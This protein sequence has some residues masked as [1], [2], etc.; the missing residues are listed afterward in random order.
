ME[1]LSLEILD[2][3]SILDCPLFKLH[4]SS[5]GLEGA[6]DASRYQAF[7]QTHVA[8]FAF[9]KG[10]E[11]SNNQ[12]WKEILY[13]V[14]FKASYAMDTPGPLEGRQRSTSSG[15]KKDIQNMFHASIDSDLSLT[16]NK[17]VLQNLIS[18]QAQLS[19][20]TVVQHHSY[21]A[22][23]W[24]YLVRNETGRDL[25]VA[26][27]AV[28]GGV[29]I[30]FSDKNSLLKHGAEVVLTAPRVA[31]EGVGSCR[32]VPQ[33]HLAVGIQGGGKASWEESTP[34]Y[35]YAPTTVVGVHELKGP[36]D[37]D[38]NATWKLRRLVCEVE[39]RTREGCVCVKLQSHTEITN[40]TGT[41]LYVLSPGIH[42]YIHSINRRA[43]LH[44]TI[45][46]YIL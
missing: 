25:L 6:G 14:P 12:A 18:L 39:Q 5:T 32:V 4:L 20:P 26:L 10:E 43:M 35:A 28:T 13:P 2:S 21:N 29:P 30:P 3:N 46:T 17:T 36:T 7:F 45:H 34:L 11:L 38:V 31:G 22:A 37:G 24:K 44:T 23:C 16:M 40:E 1:F 15:T 8:A 9:A 19:Y 41:T 42:T 33:H 27:A